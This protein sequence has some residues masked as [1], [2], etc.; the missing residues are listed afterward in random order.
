MNLE[1]KWGAI[2]GAVVMVVV[3]IQIERQIILSVRPSRWLLLFRGIIASMM[4]LLGAIIIDQIIFKEDIELAQIK[5]TEQNVREALP[6]RTEDLRLQIQQLDSVIARKEIDRKELVDDISKNP[7]IRTVTTQNQ[8]TTVTSSVTDS[9]RITRTNSRVVNTT[10]TT[11][12]SIVNP[13]LEMLG[14]LDQQ[15]AGL[16]MQKREKDSA[17]L[18]L[19]PEL[20]REIKAKVGFLDELK[21]MY[22]LVTDS[23]VALAVWLIWFFFLFGLEMLVLISKSTEKKNDYEETVMHQMNIQLKK[24]ELLGKATHDN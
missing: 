18:T 5:F 7:T 4:A 15:I 24:L 8:P 12:G 16:R 10:S 2:A 22:S 6:G 9:N 21:V 19:R 17:L 14:P 3:I 11:V 13:K 23:G 1:N 20:E